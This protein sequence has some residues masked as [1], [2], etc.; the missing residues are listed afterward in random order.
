MAAPTP[1]SSL[2]LLLLASA[3][4]AM[5]SET[6]ERPAEPAAAGRAQTPYAAPAPPAD[7]E[8][9]ELDDALA[10]YEQ[11]LAA[12]E[13]RLRSMGV[14]I[15]AREEL[16]NE[17]EAP[18]RF[19][20]P[21]SG[22][23]GAGSDPAR[24][25]EDKQAR[26]APRPAPDKAKRTRP[27][28]ASKPGTTSATP[29][30]APARAPRADVGGTAPRAESRPEAKGDAAAASERDEDDRGRCAE[31]CDLADSTCDLEG[32]ICDL[33]ARHP[34]DARY[35]DVCRR[36]DEDC[37]VAADACTQCSP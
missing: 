19:A 8:L 1:E 18:P 24:V 34:G 13:T 25:A 29:P 7:E 10:A 14:R 20:P 37:R 23:P 32:K 21:P 16:P 2:L 12:N 36:A 31:L 17:A 4:A 35:A 11:Q 15:A 28:G 33:A 22:W 30:S 5:P 3:C 9:A 27:S 6:A 26:S